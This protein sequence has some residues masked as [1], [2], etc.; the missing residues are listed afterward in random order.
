MMS[1]TLL[2]TSDN[3]LYRKKSGYIR[4]DGHRVINKVCHEHLLKKT[5]VRYFISCSYLSR[6]SYNSRPLIARQSVT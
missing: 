5:K 1:H 6:R 4:L 2:T 3:A